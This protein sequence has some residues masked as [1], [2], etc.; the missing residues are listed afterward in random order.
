MRRN[1]E[2]PE[3]SSMQGVPM[4]LESFHD[5]TGSKCTASTLKHHLTSCPSLYKYYPCLKGSLGFWRPL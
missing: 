4:Q 2:S 3:G 1:W 5:L